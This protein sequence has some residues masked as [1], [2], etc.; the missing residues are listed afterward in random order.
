MRPIDESHH[1]PLDRGAIARQIALRGR[2]AD[3]LFGVTFLSL[4]L[5]ASLLFAHVA[6]TET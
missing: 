1:D 3:G 6:P 2:N 5:A 4:T